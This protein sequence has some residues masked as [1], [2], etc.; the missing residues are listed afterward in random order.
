MTFKSD[1]AINP[2]EPN[3][4]RRD[5]DGGHARVELGRNSGN[6]PLMN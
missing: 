5:L 6:G 3:F 4:S 2:R 1:V